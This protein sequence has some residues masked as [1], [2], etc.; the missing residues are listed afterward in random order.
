MLS[1]LWLVGSTTNFLGAWSSRQLHTNF[2]FT[3][4]LLSL[5]IN[6][7]LD[8]FYL[9]SRWKFCLL[10]DKKFKNKNLNLLQTHCKTEHESDVNNFLYKNLFKKDRT[11]VTRNKCTRFDYFY[12]NGRNKKKHDILEYYQI[13]GRNPFENRLVNFKTLYENLN[14]YSIFFNNHFNSHTYHDPDDTIN[15]GLDLFSVKYKPRD[16][17]QM[18]CTFS[19]INYQ[20]LL[21]DSFAEV[22]DTRIWST[23]G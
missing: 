5:T 22:T 16:K 8:F 3:M 20:P 15:N 11:T 14:H 18:K 9:F 7:T 12:M 1:F 6:T 19:I 21:E 10:C 2:G 4:V 13:G 23:D 17:V